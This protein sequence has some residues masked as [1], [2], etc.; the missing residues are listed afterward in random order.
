MA[1]DEAKLD[2]RP[3][4]RRYHAR[5]N[6]LVEKQLWHYENQ[7]TKDPIRDHDPSGRPPDRKDPHARHVP[8]LLVHGLWQGRRTSGHR[9]Q[10]VSASAPPVL[11]WGSA[12]S[13]VWSGYSPMTPVRCNTALTAIRPRF[14]HLSTRSQMCRTMAGCSCCAT[15]TG[16]TNSGSMAT[17]WT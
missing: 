1:C 12:S 13:S 14:A 16:T 10:H 3:L 5:P 6:Q 4:S 11:T 17:S 2:G 15:T 8:R 9:R 7:D